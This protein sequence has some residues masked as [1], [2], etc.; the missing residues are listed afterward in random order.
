MG[1]FRVAASAD[2]S[3]AAVDAEAS[4]M[5][6][7]EGLTG[8]IE[9][10]S[11]PAPA[12]YIATE[13]PAA[14]QADIHTLATVT[15]GDIHHDVALKGDRIEVGRV[16]S[17][18]I[19]LQD[20]NVSRRHAAFLREGSGWVIEDMGSTNGTVVNGNRVDRVRLQ[21]RDVIQIGITE[22]T[23]HEPRT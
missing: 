14:P 9:A 17:C 11:A 22:L 12:E 23:Y 2:T 18:D 20:A 6:V 15:V 3:A 8:A 4:R 5:D 19:C 7:S 21:D 16:G 10:L 1:R 13:K